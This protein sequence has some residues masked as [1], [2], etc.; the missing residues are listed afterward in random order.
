[1]YLCIK[2]FHQGVGQRS[3]CFVQGVL[4]PQTLYSLLSLQAVLIS[5]TWMLSECAFVLALQGHC[6]ITF[7]SEFIS[8][9]GR[10]VWLSETLPV[11]SSSCMIKVNYK[12]A[13]CWL[14]FFSIYS[15]VRQT[16]WMWDCSCEC[17]KWIN[18]FKGKRPARLFSGSIKEHRKL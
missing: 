2:L 18:L 10:Q 17:C 7:R 9:N 5:G 12:F 6:C 4:K 1:M 3:A 15:S 14:Y 11:R 13:K 8:Q 16:C